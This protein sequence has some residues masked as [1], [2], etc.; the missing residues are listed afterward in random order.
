MNPGPF[1]TNLWHQI[2]RKEESGSK[3]IRLAESVTE[4]QTFSFRNVKERPSENKTKAAWWRASPFPRQRTLAGFFYRSLKPCSSAAGNAPVS[5]PIPRHWLQHPPSLQP[6][7]RWWSCPSDGRPAGSSE[8]W[9][10][11][12]SQHWAFKECR[13]TILRAVDPI[14][15]RDFA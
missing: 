15:S 1:S 14:P 8:H 5:S 12:V 10:E 9:P 3:I 11:R 4:R 7:W 13:C 6:T 2:L